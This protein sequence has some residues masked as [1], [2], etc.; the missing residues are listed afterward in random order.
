M[1]LK[2]LK[3][4]L[5]ENAEACGIPENDI[6]THEHIRAAAHL[7]SKKIPKIVKEDIQGFDSFIVDKMFR[8]HSLFRI[9]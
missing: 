2:Y 3:K 1:S 4:S 6:G 5:K 8:Y 9:R 7:P